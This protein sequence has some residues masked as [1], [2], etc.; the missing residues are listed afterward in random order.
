MLITIQ[1]EEIQMDK[2]ETLKIDDV[3][4]VRKDS[5]PVMTYERSEG[6]W[7]IGKKYLIRT[8]T[9]IQHGTLIDVTYNELV[10]SG[11]SWIADTGRFSDFM[12]GRI[13]PTEVEPWP[14]NKIV[15]VGRGSLIDAVQ[16][17]GNFSKQK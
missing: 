10:L 2:P 5:I 12:P 9:M 14:Q 11:A 16:M 1:S 8:V 7:H 4:Y 15:I 6:P 3:E 13:E 17:D